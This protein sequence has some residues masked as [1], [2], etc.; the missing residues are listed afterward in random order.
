MEAE[1]LIS[2]GILKN[3]QSHPANENNSQHT[4]GCIQSR[5]QVSRG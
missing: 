2:T 5:W 4:V 3:Q 1:Y